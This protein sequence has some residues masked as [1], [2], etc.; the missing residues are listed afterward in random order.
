MPKAV[1]VAYVVY[2]AN[3]L[4]RM[5]AFL[6]DFGLVTAR[7]QP[8]QLCMR[9]AG[10][11]PVVHVTRLGAAPCFLGGA[12]RMSSR[13]DLTALSRLPGSS[14]VEPIEDLPGGGWR[15]RMTTPDGVPIDAVWGQQEAAPLPLRAPNPFNAGTVKARVNSSLRPRRE[16]GLVLR[17]GHFGLRVSNHPQ[18]VAWFRERFGMLDSD[19]LCV[20]GDESQVIGTFLRFDRGEELVDHHTMLVVQ[21]K[22]PGVHHSSFEMQDIDALFG[23]HDYLLERGYQLECGVG[24]HLV[25]SQIFDYWRD[26]FGLRV[27]HYTDGDV[28]NIHYEAKRYA[29][30]ADETTQWGMQPPKTFFD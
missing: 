11:A 19:Y 17:F 24:R 27:E 5:E 28:S 22:D 29:V 20:P 4:D 15:V 14:G 10:T 12:F 16:P 8:D 3:D 9:G 7:R 18:S 26:P 2:Q 30:P 13:D 23:A 6:R 21:S 1:D 25:G